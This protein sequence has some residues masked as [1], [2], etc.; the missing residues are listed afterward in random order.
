M[1][2]SVCTHAARD[3]AIVSSDD[4]DDCPL[5]TPQLHLT[6]L[7]AHH[8]PPQAQTGAGQTE[9]SEERQTGHHG[10]VNCLT[11][12]TRL[13]PSG[14]PLPVLTSAPVSKSPRQEPVMSTVLLIGTSSPHLLLHCPRYLSGSLSL[15]STGEIRILIVTYQ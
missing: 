14:Q 2:P 10:N 11:V 6:T 15:R 5:L 8:L 3:P 13:R 4:G 7:A 1:S 9:E 12:Q